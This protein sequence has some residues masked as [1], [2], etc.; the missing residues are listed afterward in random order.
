MAL[1]GVSEGAGRQ[2]AFTVL[3][4][5]K[6]KGFVWAWLERI[7]PKQA[8]VPSDAVVAVR[9]KDQAEKA[10]LLAGDPEV[11]FTEPHYD[12]FP[13]VLVRLRAVKVPQ[14]R[15]LL[16]EAWRCMAPRE[17]QEGAPSPG[18]VGRPQTK[19]RSRAKTRR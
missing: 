4:K 14:L 18:K 2:L 1:P 11:F 3:V 6:A 13:A 10:M 7:H 15:R 16:H 12:G 8:R 17:L 19:S 5:G 9:V